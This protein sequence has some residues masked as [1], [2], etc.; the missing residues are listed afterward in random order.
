VSQ[1]ADILEALLAAGKLHRVNDRTCMVPCSR[2]DGSLV[3][4]FWSPGYEPLAW[5]DSE[6]PALW[7]PVGQ[8]GSLAVI[9]VGVESTIAITALLYG[10]V[11]GELR[12]RPNL[13][14][15]LADAVPVC[16]PE[17]HPHLPVAWLYETGPL[18]LVDELVSASCKQAVLAILAGEPSTVP[19]LES[20]V[21]LWIDQ[22]RA[23]ASPAGL[24]VALIPLQPGSSLPDL[25]AFPGE[26]RRYAFAGAL[27]SAFHTAPLTP[28]F[29]RY[30]EPTP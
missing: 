22:F 20:T 28:L 19:A 11:D 10:V 7:W 2:H 16:L 24:T 25:F 14:G 4:H 26:G 5:R 17:D 6:A 13:P 27:E 18:R 21:Q 3:E 12:R 29:H 15:P 8:E 9:T 23:A 1:H 30:P